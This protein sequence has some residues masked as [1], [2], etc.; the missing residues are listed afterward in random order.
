MERA[1]RWR[2]A[3]VADVL[4]HLNRLATKPLNSADIAAPPVTVSRRSPSPG[5][6]SPR[7]PTV[8]I[9]PLCKRSPL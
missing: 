6:Y 4:E 5:Y 8:R 1:K 2:M 7:P 9:F 3:A